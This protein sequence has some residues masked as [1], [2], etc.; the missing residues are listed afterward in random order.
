M[1]I[2]KPTQCERI[3][4]LLTERGGLGVEVW[5]MI[6]PQPRG[7]G[8]AQYNAR[9]YQLRRKGWSIISKDDK[10][11][12]MNNLQIKEENEKLLSI[13]REEYKTAAKERQDEIK[14]EVDKLLLHCP[15]CNKVLPD[16]MEYSYCS[17]DCREKAWGKVEIP[18]KRKTIAEMKAGLDKMAIETK[19]RKYDPTYKI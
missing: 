4:D 7:L 10:F 2:S 1:L 16:E 3:L 12:L 18:H 11:F 6:A 15:K 14:K 5:E 17:D 13:L 19:L 9:I 8:I